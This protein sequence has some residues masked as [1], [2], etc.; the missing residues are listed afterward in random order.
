MSRT[1]SCPYSNAWKCTADHISMQDIRSCHT[2][3][4]VQKGNKIYFCSSSFMRQLPSVLCWRG[5]WYIVARGWYNPAT[6]YDRMNISFMSI[7]PSIRLC[8]FSIIT[9]CCS[10]RSSKK[11]S[12][13][14]AVHRPRGF[15]VKFIT[16]CAEIAFKYPHS[17]TFLLI[18]V[19]KYTY[20]QN[21]S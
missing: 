9:V 16:S 2:R 18:N 13:A 8:V 4:I 1:T 14:G 6:V 11:R 3:S 19:S 12:F 10:K 15:A 17:V 20:P 21:I 5:L 7:R